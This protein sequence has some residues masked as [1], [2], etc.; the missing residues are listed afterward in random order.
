MFLVF[1]NYPFRENKYFLMHSEKVV[2]GQL[3]ILKL[4]QLV[5]ALSKKLAQ[6]LGNSKNMRAI[7]DFPMYE[8]MLANRIVKMRFWQTRN[9]DH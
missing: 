2:I 1:D 6:L 4:I 7:A 3:L 8:H 5:H 9:P